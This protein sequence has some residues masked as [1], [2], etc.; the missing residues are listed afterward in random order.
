MNQSVEIP[1]NRYEILVSDYSAFEFLGLKDNF[2]NK[3]DV[4][5][6]V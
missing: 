4:L 3:G 6:L 5:T 1:I 2:L